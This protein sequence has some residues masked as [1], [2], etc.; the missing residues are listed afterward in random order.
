M[1]DDRR[2]VIPKS[3]EADARNTALSLSPSMRRAMREGVVK[4][5]VV[6]VKSATRAALNA[7]AVCDDEG[8]FTEIG[9]ATAISFLSLRRQC[10][11]LSIPLDRVAARWD[12]R[13]EDAAL[14]LL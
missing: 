2:F 12:G 13:S 14:E 9:R 8:R 6:D 11:L 3:W 4:G 10:E 7:R 5:D 1:L